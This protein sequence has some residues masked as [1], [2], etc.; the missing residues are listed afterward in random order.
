MHEYVNS[1][2]KGKERLQRFPNGSQKAHSS[3]VSTL[4]NQMMDV[5]SDIYKIYIQDSK[6]A[7]YRLEMH[8][9]LSLLQL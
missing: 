3:N 5:S 8:K 6:A 4:N 9:T 1:A 2:P 7:Q